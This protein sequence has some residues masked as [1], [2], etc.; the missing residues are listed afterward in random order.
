MEMFYILNHWHWW[1]MAAL[2]IIAELLNPNAYFLAIGVA[3]FL[4]GLVVLF[5]P[6]MPGLWQL[7]LFVVLLIITT[8]TARQFKRT[9]QTNAGDEPPTPPQNI[10]P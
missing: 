6:Y 9:H 2:W 4:A 7:G 1:A 3:A 5:Q 10:Q 8:A